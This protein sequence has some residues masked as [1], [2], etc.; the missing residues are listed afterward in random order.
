MINRDTAKKQVARLAGLENYPRWSDEALRELVVAMQSA[1]SEDE[2]I[3]VVTDW[4]N[5][6]GVCPKPADLRK[7]FFDLKDAEDKPERPYCRKC[8][9]SGFVMEK[10][11]VEPCPG[12]K[13]EADFAVP[14]S[15]RAVEAKQ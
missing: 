11:I 14:C 13:Y 7:L 10:R 15:C 12:I 8:S 4:V 9:N 6:N 5:H 3:A 2:A 1:A